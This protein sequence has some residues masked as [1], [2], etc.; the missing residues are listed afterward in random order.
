LVR[1]PTAARPPAAAAPPAITGAPP[2]PRKRPPTATGAGGEEFAPIPPA[3]GKPRTL[4][5]LNREADGLHALTPEARAAVMDARKPIK[6]GEWLWQKEPLLYKAESFEGYERFLGSGQVDDAGKFK[7]PHLMR[8]P[9]LKQLLSIG[10]GGAVRARETAIRLIGYRQGAFKEIEQ[11]KAKDAVMRW[12]GDA[13][14]QFGFTKVRGRLGIGKER[15]EARNVEVLDDSSP[16]SR[17]IYDLVEHPERYRL[18]PDQTKT[19][20]L[21]DNM[22]TQLLR[23]EQRTGLDVLEVLEDYWPRIIVGKPNERRISRF[24][25]SL[26]GGKVGTGGAGKGHTRGRVFEFA[27]DTAKAGFELDTHPLRVLGQRLDAGIGLLAERHARNALFKLPEFR[28]STQK[29]LQEFPQVFESAQAARVARDAAKKA[30][31]AS[32]DSPEAFTALRQAEAQYLLARSAFLRTRRISQQT[33][34]S[35]S[36]VSGRIVPRELADEVR[37]FIDL[38]ESPQRGSLIGGTIQETAR[39]VRVVLTNVDIAAG[40]IQ[41]QALFYRNNVAWLRAQRQALIALV[42]DPVAYVA[43]N[44]EVRQEGIRMGAISVPTEYMFTGSGI[45]SIPTRLPLIGSAFRSFNRAFEW[46]ITVGQTELYKAGRG[47]KSVEELV[48]LGRAIRRGLGTESYAILGV[49]PTQQTIEQMMFFAARFMRANVGIMKQAF[50]GGAGGAEARKLMG[51]LIAGGTSLLIG[52][53]WATKRKLPNFDDPF[54]SDWMS[55]KQGKRLYNPFGPFY[56]YFR[57]I[58]RSGVHVANG[59]PDKARKEIQRFLGFKAGIPFRAYDMI[60]QFDKYG[61][62]RSFEGERFPLTPSG[63]LGAVQEETTPISLSEAWVAIKEGEPQR[64]LAEVF[65]ILG[66]RDYTA[67]AVAA[68]ESQFFPKFSI[69]PE[70]QDDVDSELKRL[71]IGVGSAGRK[72]DDRVLTLEGRSFYRALADGEIKAALAQ[73]VDLASYKRRSEKSKEDVIRRSI[74]RARDK[75]RRNVLRQADIMEGLFEDEETEVQSAPV[76]DEETAKATPSATGGL[77]TRVRLRIKELE[78][79]EVP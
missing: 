33:S 58:A 50:T 73:L 60:A 72:I 28:T 36:R 24:L 8:V 51:S 56:G 29:L 37:K 61:S 79:A 65:G 31:L 43:K 63:V 30:Y 27:D 10:S 15:W 9:G 18:T 74:Q 5:D 77:L 71:D 23:D 12:W 64:I 40:Y 26:I 38:P 1:A 13:K 32:K 16:L 39:L 70:I 54:R 20:R 21:A 3:P 45:A 46:F 7:Y 25:R 34:L 66:R 47:G 11:A 35:E 42:D 69:T 57:T 19:L 44:F 62:F 55:T 2:P 52:V 53:E 48:S 6:E 17:T 49:R 76:L 75:A 22:T 67:G 14:E 68:K 4:S 41:G 78:A 59:E